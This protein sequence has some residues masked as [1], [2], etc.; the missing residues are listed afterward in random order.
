MLENLY[1]KAY[2]LSC[3][4]VG[5]NILECFLSIGAGILAGSIA[6]VG[7]G[8]DSFIESLS[9]GIMIWR[10]SRHEKLSIDEE[11]KIEERAIKLIGYTF[12]IFGAYVFYESFSK[13]YFREKPEPS[14]LGIIIAT[15]SIIVMP[16]LFYLKYQTGKAI[17]SKSLIADSKETLVC[18]FLSLSLL[19]GLGLNYVYGLWWADPVVGLIIVFFLVHEGIETLKEKLE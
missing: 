11:Q 2:I 13:L 17:K 3:F 9:G 18:T 1:K 19:V 8:I 14:L 15:V 6:L 5:Y 7:F 10:F 4:T 16:A 12:F